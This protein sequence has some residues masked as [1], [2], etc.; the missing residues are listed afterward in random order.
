MTAH[1]KFCIN[2]WPE[3][4]GSWQIVAED[5]YDSADDGPE[6]EIIQFFKLHPQGVDY[7]FLPIFSSLK[8]LRR[9]CGFK[10]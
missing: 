9:V 10:S 7:R 1:K 2:Q 5:L 3:H 4:I 6:V 8:G